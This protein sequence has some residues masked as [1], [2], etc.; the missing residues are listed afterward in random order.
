[1]DLGKIRVFFY[2]NNDTRSREVASFYA[3]KGLRAYYII[4]GM[5]AWRPIQG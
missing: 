2:S 1:M 5:T 3:E 4:G